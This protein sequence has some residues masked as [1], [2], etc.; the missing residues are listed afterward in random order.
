MVGGMDVYSWVSQVQNGKRKRISTP[1]ALSEPPLSPPLS[2][3][4]PPADRYDMVSQSDSN[5]SPKKRKTGPLPDDLASQSG[6]L[7]SGCNLPQPANERTRESSPTRELIARYRN[8]IPPIR[9]LP[10][11]N[12]GTPDC[13]RH[14]LQTLP[15]LSRF[16]VSMI[17]SSLK[18]RS[19]PCARLTMNLL[20][21][22]KFDL[23]SQDPFKHPPPYAWDTATASKLDSDKALYTLVKDVLEEALACIDGSAAGA[24]WQKLADNFLDRTLRLPDA[25]KMTRVRV[26]SVSP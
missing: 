16:R 19:L 12:D 5:R 18:V 26:T 13:V 9:F 17:P 15:V 8:A 7:L 25:S 21:F 24:Q 14:L 2:Y 3:R 10:W 11:P 1:R 6:S 4:Q 20:L 23:D 22:L